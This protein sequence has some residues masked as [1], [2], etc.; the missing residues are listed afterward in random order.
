VV[1]PAARAEPGT[2]AATATE[3]ATEATVTLLTGDVVTL[4]GPQG[5]RVRP[6]K[7][8]EHVTFYVSEDAR[9][10]TQ[11]VP[12]DAVPLLSQGRLDQDLFN[13]SLQ[14]EVGYGDALP[15]NVGTPTVE[16][17]Y[18]DG[19]TWRRTSVRRC[20]DRWELTVDHPRDAGFVSLRS[21]VSDPDGGTQHQT[22][23]RAYALK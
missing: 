15:L 19:R 22:I 2:P 8:R 9:G 4:G 13:A 1:T 5:A 23:I 18:D 11:V 3:A 20:G 21:S 17:S 7:G 6:A 12:E 14:A 16:V 10:D